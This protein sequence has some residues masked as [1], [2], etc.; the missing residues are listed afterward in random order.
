MK[1][2]PLRLDID[3][4]QVAIHG[5]S[6]SGTMSTKSQISFPPIA[7]GGEHW[8]NSLR[9]AEAHALRAYIDDQEDGLLLNSSE[10]NNLLLTM[11]L[12]PEEV[13]QSLQMLA[14]A[15]DVVFGF[16]DD[17]PTTV[18]VQPAHRIVGMDDM[19]IPITHGREATEIRNDELGMRCDHVRPAAFLSSLDAEV[20]YRHLL[21]RNGDTL[22]AVIAACA[23]TMSMADVRAGVNALYAA[24]L[25]N[26]Y[27]EDG[28]TMLVPDAVDQ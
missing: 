13:K 18:R 21:S 12:I 11:G 4:S 8:T 19:N 1:K 28:Q 3:E 27:V 20:I 24:R 23:S 5:N 6:T 17:D 10:Y 25:I 22:K 7:T 16:D 15:G 9:C 14:N 2:L 26:A